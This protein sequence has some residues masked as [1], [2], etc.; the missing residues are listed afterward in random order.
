MPIVEATVRIA[1]PVDQ[2]YALARDIERFPE[3]MDDVE[4][5]TILEQTPGRQ[6]SRWQGVVKE[7]NRKLRWTEEDF[8]NDADHTCVFKQIEGDFSIYQGRWE[9]RPLDAELCPTQQTDA[10][11]Q[12]EYDYEVPFIGN[13]I[14]NIIYKKMQQNVETML[15][16]LKARAEQ[17]Q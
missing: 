1:A 10:Y 17:S 11:L 9:F 6:V 16:A 14:K 3:Y 12:I 2:V 7:F 13:L 8:W 4:Q 5:V 15:A